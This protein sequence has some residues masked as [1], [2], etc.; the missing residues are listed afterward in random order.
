[1][2]IADVGQDAREEID[3]APSSGG[4]VVGGAGAN[5]GWN[6]REGFIPYSGAPER[7]RNRRASPIP[8]ST[9]PTTNRAEA[10]CTAARSSAATW[11]ATRAS[12]TS[13]VATSIRDYCNEEIRSLALPA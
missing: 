12:P 9:T 2:V 3:F 10:G 6:C 11:S 4:G 13:T 8:S 1:M 5:Y 7:M